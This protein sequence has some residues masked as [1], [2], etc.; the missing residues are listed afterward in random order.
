MIL[1]FILLNAFFVIGKSTVEKWGADQSVIIFGNLLLFLASLFSFLLLQRSLA[2]TNPNVFVRAIYTSFIVKFFVCAIAAAVYVLSAPS[3]NKPALITCMFL[4]LIY[5]TIEV[6]S[7]MKLLKQ[8][9][10]A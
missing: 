9:K 6:G 5:T 10:N 2:A 3:V 4:Y 1:I 7:L 8:K